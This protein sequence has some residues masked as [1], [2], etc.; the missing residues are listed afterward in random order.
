MFQS[1][2]TDYLTHRIDLNRLIGQ[3]PGGIPQDTWTWRSY[4]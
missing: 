2:L 3:D 4:E 1:Q